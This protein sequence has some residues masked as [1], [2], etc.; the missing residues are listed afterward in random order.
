MP[1]HSNLSSLTVGADIKTTD[2]NFLLFRY[3]LSFLEITNLRSFANSNRFKF[4]IDSSVF[5]AFDSLFV[6]S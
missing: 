4:L 3:G 1:F 2:I 6:V 5:P